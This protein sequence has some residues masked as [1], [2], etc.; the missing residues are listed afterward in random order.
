VYLEVVWQW[1]ECLRVPVSKS[2][3]RVTFPA[4]VQTTVP[5]KVPNQS[6]GRSKYY[7]KFGRYMWIKQVRHLTLIDRLIGSDWLNA[8]TIVWRIASRATF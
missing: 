6:P 8:L 7:I 1:Q 3:V 5:T 4:P 2:G